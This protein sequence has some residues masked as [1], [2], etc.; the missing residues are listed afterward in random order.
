MTEPTTSNRAM[1][2][3]QIIGL[4]PQHCDNDSAL[5]VLRRMLLTSLPTLPHPS[6][7]ATNNTT[8][9]IEVTMDEAPRFYSILLKGRHLNEW[10]KRVCICVR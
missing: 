8:L 2:R 1:E 3:F 9:S 5:P 7:L 10:W 4:H 6:S